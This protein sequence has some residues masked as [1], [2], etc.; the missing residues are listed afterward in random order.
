MI[1]HGMLSSQT[2]LQALW[3]TS[4]LVRVCHSHTHPTVHKV[5]M[6]TWQILSRQT[7]VGSLHVQHAQ[8]WLHSAFIH[9]VLLNITPQPAPKLLNLEG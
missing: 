3:T 5:R 2:S 7:Y 1:T 6:T 9:H 8:Y 4:H